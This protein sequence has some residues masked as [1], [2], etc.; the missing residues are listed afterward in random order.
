MQ[1]EHKFLGKHFEIKSKNVRGNT[2]S[3]GGNFEQ[4]M[5]VDFDAA[6]LKAGCC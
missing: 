2:C 1:T 4:L 5:L 6:H 3:I